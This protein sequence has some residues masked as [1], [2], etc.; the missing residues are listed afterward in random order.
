MMI[1]KSMNAKLNAQVTAEFSAAHTYLSMSCAFDGMGL[2]ILAK[3]FRSQYTEELEHGIKIVDYVQEVGGAVTLEAV[4]QPVAEYADA[5]ALVSA[6]LNSE[7]HITRL[8]NDLVALADKEKDYATRSFLTW[9]VDE[10]VEE[11][12][13]MSAL[14]DLVRLA[15]GNML[16]VENR[17][18][19]E[20]SPQG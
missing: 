7:Q 10:Q 8:I 13:S 9:F 5:E 20:M 2:R 14:L 6:A 15:D 4:P 19:H 17:V 1:S 11:I 12:A 18:R 3:R 16:Q